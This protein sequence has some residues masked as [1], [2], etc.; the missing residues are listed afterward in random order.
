MIRV[1]PSDYI[2]HFRH[3]DVYGSLGCQ[4]RNEGVRIGHMLENMAYK[5]D[6]FYIGNRIRF[7]ENKIGDIAGL[8][9]DVDV[10][11]VDEGI[12]VL[13]AARAS[14]LLNCILSSMFLTIQT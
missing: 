4:L 7:S 1:D 6:P 8:D 2:A 14:P 11:F 3:Y 13:G 5:V 9:V 10:G 12:E